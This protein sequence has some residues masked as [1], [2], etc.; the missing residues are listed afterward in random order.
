MVNTRKH[1]TSIVQGLLMTVLI[2]LAATLTPL[3]AGRGQ[4]GHGGGLTISSE[5][6]TLE[7][8]VTAVEGAVLSGGRF[9]LEGELAPVEAE[10]PAAAGFEI[11][12]FPDEMSRETFVIDGALVPATEGGAIE[13]EG[14]LVLTPEAIVVVT[15]AGDPFSGRTD[16]V[17]AY[18]DAEL[19]GLLVVHF[20]EDDQ[21]VPGDEHVILIADSI[22]GEFADV[23]CPELPEGWWLR[24]ES[25]DGE[26]VI[27][28][29]AE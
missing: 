14:D 11:S 12:G 25:R 15:L 29:E 20:S 23:Q 27:T 18:G 28:I 19:A 16:R 13:F 3:R 10:G 17:T 26:L 6:F 22:A 2:V 8:E 24:L 7:S 9:T 5:R 1:L 21:P 4:G